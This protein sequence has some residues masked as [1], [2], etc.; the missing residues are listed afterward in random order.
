M[1]SF[2]QPTVND[3]LTEDFSQDVQM[4][5]PS[6]ENEVQKKMK[7]EQSQ[8]S[9]MDADAAKAATDSTP[10]VKVT[11]VKCSLCQCRLESLLCARDHY[12]GRRHQKNFMAA[13]KAKH[14][15]PEKGPKGST[16][17]EHDGDQEGVLMYCFVCD[18]QVNSNDQ[19][20]QHY[21][22]RKHKY[23][24]SLVASLPSASDVSETNLKRKS[25]VLASSEQQKADGENKP[26]VVKKSGGPKAQPKP[27]ATTPQQTFSCTS[28]GV[29]VTS[30]DML[31]AHLAGSKHR[32]T[33]AR[34]GGIGIPAPSKKTPKAAMTATGNGKTANTSSN[35]A[36]TPST[37][38]CITCD[39]CSVTMNSQTQYEQHLQSQKHK[40]RLNGVGTTHV[41]YQNKGAFGGLAGMSNYRKGTR[42]FQQFGYKKFVKGG[43]A[44]QN[45]N[46]SR[47]SINP[48]LPP[49]PP[50]SDVQDW[51][52]SQWAGPGMGMLQ[53]ATPL[54]PPPDFPQT[55]GY[56]YQYET[57]RPGQQ[58]TPR[59]GRPDL[60]PKGQNAY[61]QPPPYMTYTTD[62]NYHSL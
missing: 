54:V 16:K 31:D 4:F 15:D 30:K 17:E 61:P 40:N 60:K 44:N 29:N 13:I 20:L 11:E 56:G 26:P 38:L 62:E 42:K 53:G 51:N 50:Q 3:P 10:E 22:G 27:K 52:N 43:T 28:C 9:Q 49:P 18:I 34:L 24:S 7:E 41:P 2:S 32:K 12:E 8:P 1:E 37:V 55:E 58:G 6:A 36:G 21:T 48:P 57:G 47:G 46:W 25:Q 39:V 19:A 45:H 59:F 5:D 23:R 35:N 33:M 14:E